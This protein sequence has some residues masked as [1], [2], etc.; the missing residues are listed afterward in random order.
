[1]AP[2]DASF[3]LRRAR[4]G[5]IDALVRLEAH[6]PTD[7][8]RRRN[9]R[10]LLHRGNAALFVV[11][12]AGTAVADAIVL[13]RRSCPRARLYSLVV[14]PSHR[15]R[16]LAAVLLDAAEHAARKRGCTALL[17]EVRPDNPD[18]RLLYTQRGYA[19]AGSIPGFYEDGTAA[20]RLIKPLARIE[21]R[22]RAFPAA[23]TLDASG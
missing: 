15:R 7:R 11:D 10:H 12:C 2:A 17:L 23:V 6:F 3:R 22:A 9:L 18:A 13:F 1:V 4:A 14:E 20:L 16:G 19:S 5:D 8:L 21:R